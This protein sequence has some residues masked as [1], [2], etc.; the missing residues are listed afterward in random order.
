MGFFG[1]IMGLDSDKKKDQFQ[2]FDN[3]ELFEKKVRLERKYDEIVRLIEQKDKEINSLIDKSKGTNPNEKMRIANSIRTLQEKKVGFDNNLRTIEEDLRALSLIE[4]IKRHD[5]IKEIGII[6]K[7][8]FETAQQELI[9]RKVKGEERNEK[10]QN[11]AQDLSNGNVPVKYDD[12]TIQIFNMLNEID[13]DNK[14]D[15]EPEQIKKKP[16]QKEE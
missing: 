6:H 5:E 10:V 12:D 13:K 15:C 2:K 8:N 11:L 9:E 16:L 7:I 4:D 14:E 1:K 3:E